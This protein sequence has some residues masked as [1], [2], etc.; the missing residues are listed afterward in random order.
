M[1]DTTDTR[2]TFECRMAYCHLEK[3]RAATEGGKAKYSITALIPKDSPAVPGI[4]AA[5]AAAKTK[6][7]GAKPPAGL[8]PAVRDGDEKDPETDEFL[9]KGEE[10]RNHWYISCSS[11][12]QVPT[13]AGKN[14]IPAT[15]DQMV[16]GYYAAASVNFYGYD[17]SGSKGVAAGLNAVWIIRKGEVLGSGDATAAFDGMK[18][19]ADDFA[20]EVFAGAAERKS[21][22]IE[23]EF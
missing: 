22:V 17:V 13:V 21:T 23:D 10:F 9:R 15:P 11:E 20:A 19:E 8:K 1:T 3:P 4:K 14:R 7:W 5:V 16:S 6:K 12:R 18:V 2:L